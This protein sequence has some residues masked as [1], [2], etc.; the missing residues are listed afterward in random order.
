[1]NR[2]KIHTAKIIYLFSIS[3]LVCVTMVH[4]QKDCCAEKA[5]QRF[6]FLKQIHRSNTI[7][8]N[9]DGTFVLHKPYTHKDKKSYSQHAYEHA[10]AYYFI[11]RDSAIYYYNE[12]TANE[13]DTEEAVFMLHS[14]F[15]TRTYHKLD[16]HQITR[17]KVL[18]AEKYEKSAYKDIIFDI[19]KMYALDQS[20]RQFGLICNFDVQLN[21]DI[22]QID[23][24]NLLAVKKMISKYGYPTISMIGAANQNRLFILIQHADRDIVFQKAVLEKMRLLLPKEE[25]NKENYAYLFDRVMT[26]TEGTQYYGTQ[27]GGFPIIDS[28]H[29][30]ERRA[31]QNL[32]AMSTER[33]SAVFFDRHVDTN[34][35]FP[36]IF[37]DINDYRINNKGLDS[38]NVIIKWMKKNPTTKIDILGYAD[39][40]GNPTDNMALSL[41]RAEET[42]NQLQMNCIQRSRLN[43]KAMGALVAAKSDKQKSRK[44]QIKLAIRQN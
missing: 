14:Y 32:P 1:M 28:V 16:E 9:L 40:T 22:R 5:L 30:N 43:I 31:E 36:E 15:L 41:K 37:F 18:F 38:M 7:S 13:Y 34:F 20:V 24:I 42:A 29:V 11:N 27:F 25:V 17:L 4:A 21:K 44:V 26:A 33:N 8:K 39:E 2:L 35:V 19:Q 12:A 6:S 10:I 3:L 23:S